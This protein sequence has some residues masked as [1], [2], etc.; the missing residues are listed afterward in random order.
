MIYKKFLQY[1]ELD[2]A[3]AALSTVLSRFKN[4]VSLH[5]VKKRMHRGAYGSSIQDIIETSNIF[6]IYAE[7]LQ[8]NLEEL[9]Q[10]IKKKEII[11][12]FIAHINKGEG[13]THFVVIKNIFNRKV[14]IFDPSSGDKQ[15]N[16]NEFNDLWTGNIVAFDPKSQKFKI[17]ARTSIK[18]TLSLIYPYRRVL[19]VA[20]TLIFGVSVFSIISAKAY[21]VIIDNFIHIGNNNSITVFNSILIEKNIFFSMLVGFYFFKN[22][23][24]Y[25]TSNLLTKIDIKIQLL[26]QN[27]F[28][29]KFISLPSQFI[30]S[31]KVGDSLTRLD[32]INSLSG[33]ISKV[34]TTFLS[35]IIMIIVIGTTLI[36][37]RVDLFLIVVIICLLYLITCLYMIPKFS[38]KQR[39]TMEYE[40]RVITKFSESIDIFELIKVQILEKNYLQKLSIATKKLMD[41]RRVANLLENQF[42]FITTNIKELGMLLITWFGIGLIQSN[43]LSLGNMIVFQNLTGMFLSSIASL[44]ILQKEHQQFVVS[45]ERLLE[46]KEVESENYG[47]NQQL[48]SY[49]IKIDNLTFSYGSKN[50]INNLSVQFNEGDKIFI[51][52]PNGSGKS[53]F[54]KI[55]IKLIDNYQ[56]EIYLDG[57]NYQKLSVDTIRNTIGYSSTENKV[58]SG[59]LYDNLFVNG[60]SSDQTKLFNKMVRSGIFENLL[61]NLDYGFETS[62]YENGS[63]LSEGQKQIISFCRTILS[64]R[65]ILIFDEG[66]SNI[67]SDTENKLLKFMFENLK[68]NILLFIDHGNKV[69]D[70]CD[71]ILD[72][73]TGKLVRKERES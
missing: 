46:Y 52:G 57:K 11:F 10:A 65:K 56:G 16:I 62:I 69:A 26:L 6:G 40:A 58:F 42:N 55:L 60:N 28:F 68:D 24:S 39:E 29:E 15:L 64:R 35:D 67:D 4:K 31:K 53:T 61:K 73:E 34:I 7:G 47:Q 14:F 54:A 12:P 27:E 22:I 19:Y 33:F 1:D 70:V 5:E 36:N 8:G 37:I 13:L 51:K 48:D 43:R 3:A 21:Q 25:I 41:I 49:N 23:I 63:N 18:D 71:F 66:F 59:S 30:K 32:D 17:Y 2:C 44:F 38:Q 9:I 45:F 20:S 72:I 50:L